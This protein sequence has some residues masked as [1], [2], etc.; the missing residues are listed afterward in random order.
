ML[1]VL[2]SKAFKKMLFTETDKER[3]MHETSSGLHA[4]YVDRGSNVVVFFHYQFS[5]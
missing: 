2:K 4:L 3:K 1:R 5:L